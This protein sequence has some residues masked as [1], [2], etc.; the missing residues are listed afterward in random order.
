MATRA[1]MGDLIARV[2]LLVNDPA[3]TSAV[4]TDQE[5]QDAL[6]AHRRDVRY[7]P[8]AEAPTYGAGGTVSYLEY[9]AGRSNWEADAVVQDGDYTTLTPASVDY[10]G[11]IVTFA[12]NQ[13]PPLTMTGKTYDLYAA[14]AD[15]V[16]AW[17]AKVARDYDFSAQGQ[18]FHRSQMLRS[19][20]E[21][22]QTLRNAAGAGSVNGSGMT[23]IR[24]EDMN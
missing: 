15:I 22:A 10:T 17:Q 21:L 5:I 24:R 2:R 3:G 11:G 9:F 16:T 1:T 20:G 4:F 6:D 13:D 18:T 14:A 23:I 8:L 19:L 12:T 7:L